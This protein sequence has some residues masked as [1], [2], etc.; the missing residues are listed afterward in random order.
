MKYLL[1]GKEK[2]FVLIKRGKLTQA[3][4][5]THLLKVGRSGLENL[6]RYEF[7]HKFF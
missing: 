7:F 1:D 5:V 2:E 3:Y 4:E 6:S